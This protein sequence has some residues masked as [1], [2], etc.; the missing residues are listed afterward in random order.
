[1]TVKIISKSV[2][3]CSLIVITR[4][5][6]AYIFCI[7]ADFFTEQIFPSLIIPKSSRRATLTIANAKSTL[8]AES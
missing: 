8:C 6:K 7:F 4:C 5:F 2:K 3:I 1:M